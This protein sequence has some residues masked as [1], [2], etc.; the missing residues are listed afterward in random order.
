MD[1]ALSPET[2]R[3]KALDYLTADTLLDSAERADVLH[4]AEWWK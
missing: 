1:T 2:C 3:L 4:Y